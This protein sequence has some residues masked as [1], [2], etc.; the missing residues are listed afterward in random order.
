MR[1]VLINRFLEP[2]DVIG[3]HQLAKLEGP[4]EREKVIGIDHQFHFLSHGFSPRLHALR[5][6]GWAFRLDGDDH[7]EPVRPLSDKGFG[8]LDE[9]FLGVLLEPKRHIGGHR[10]LRSTETPPNWFLV[11]FPFDVPERDVDGAYRRAPHTGLRPRVERR[12]QLMPD[13]LGL[14]RIFAAQERRRLAIDELP[15]PKTLRCPGQSI[16]R[17]TLIGFDSNKNDRCPDLLF[18]KRHIYGNTMKSRLNVSDLH[19]SPLYF[20]REPQLQRMK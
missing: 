9:L 12:V 3:L 18:E 13:A 16:T 7:L 6:P 4:I 17:D 5:I 15:G 14:N 20:F 8:H 1:I 10:I 2:G 11:I 19:M